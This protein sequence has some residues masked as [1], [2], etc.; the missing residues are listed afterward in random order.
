MGAAP[1]AISEPLIR[2]FDLFFECVRLLFHVADVCHS[3]PKEN[4]IDFGS[5]FR[6]ASGVFVEALA[7]FCYSKTLT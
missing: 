3:I 5:A 4:W 1:C 2:D 7:P 6:R